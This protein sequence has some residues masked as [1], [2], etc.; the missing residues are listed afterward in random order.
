[1]AVYTAPDCWKVTAGAT[2][3]PLPGFVTDVP[4][5]CAR[6]STFTFN[7]CISSFFALPVCMSIVLNALLK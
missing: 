5:I 1:V 3:Y 2:V 4:L 7:K 6:L